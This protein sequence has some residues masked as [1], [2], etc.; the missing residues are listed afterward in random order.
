V[1]PARNEEY[2]RFAAVL[3]GPVPHLKWP[4]LCGMDQVAAIR[5]AISAS[6]GLLEMRIRGRSLKK[7]HLEH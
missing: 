5:S 1:T 4:N 6:F 2:T 3:C 7:L